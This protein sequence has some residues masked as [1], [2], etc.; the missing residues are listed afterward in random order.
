MKLCRGVLLPGAPDHVTRFT[1]NHKI[2]ATFK[3]IIADLGV[4]FQR[5]QCAQI[6]PRTRTALVRLRRTRR[7]LQ[8]RGTK[9]SIIENKLGVT[10]S[11]TCTR[12]RTYS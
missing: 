5:F 4:R 11:I 3:V 8:R 9:R 10:E 6:A 7:Y 12:N 1:N 2:H